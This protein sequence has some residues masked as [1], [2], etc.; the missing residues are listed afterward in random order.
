MHGENIALGQTSAEA[1]FTAWMNSD[2][3]RAN[4]MNSSYTGLYVSLYKQSS[5]VNIDGVN[6]AGYC[7]VQIFTRG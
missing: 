6:Y 4:M 2:G 7:W 1:V 3:H 5:G